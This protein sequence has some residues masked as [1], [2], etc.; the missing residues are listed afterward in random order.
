MLEYAKIKSNRRKFIALTGLTP[1]EFKL[2]LPAFERAYTHRYPVTQTMTGNPRRRKPGGGQK[3]KLASTE[4]KL[5]FALVYLKT[6]PLQVLLG[7][8]FDMDQS[9]A[10]RWLH[11]LLP[12]LQQALK[13][14]GV[15]PERNPRQFARRERKS[16]EPLDMIIDGTERRRHR[17]KNKT[18]RDEH[19]SGHKKQHSD[20][21]VVIANRKTKRISF[22]SQTYAGKVQDK[23]IADTERIAYPRRARLR[24][25]TGFQAYEPRGVET[26][27]PKKSRV[28][29]S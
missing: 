15:Q 23:K 27:Q 19:Y 6:Y 22:L 5:L 1:K 13:D 17:P 28:R 21:N 2:L 16:G 18:K 7:E 9:R 4:Q 24:K 20:K 29:A 8:M 3:S 10:N 14:L 11:Q 25:D 12:I 26:F